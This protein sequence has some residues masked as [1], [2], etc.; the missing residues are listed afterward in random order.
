MMR[1]DAERPVALERPS[2]AAASPDGPAGQI[3][4]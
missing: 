1:F 2:V 4:A 3:R